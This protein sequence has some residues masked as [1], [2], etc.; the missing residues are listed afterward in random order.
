[1]LD[2]EIFLRCHKSYIVN[3]KNIVNIIKQ[4]A[5]ACDGSKIPI[6]REKRMEVEFEMG[7]LSW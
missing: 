4:E 2:P 6:S 7:K 5:E 1:M 3:I